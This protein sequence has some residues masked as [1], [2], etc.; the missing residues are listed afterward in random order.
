M[1]TMK[2]VQ[3]N[4]AFELFCKLNEHHK[5]YLKLVENLDDEQ[6]ALLNAKLYNYLKEVYNIEK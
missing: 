3:V 4:L 1:D 5:C 2:T 6:L